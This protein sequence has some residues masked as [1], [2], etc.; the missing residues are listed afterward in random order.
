MAEKESQV[1]RT[2]DYVEVAAAE[3]QARKKTR[4]AKGPSEQRALNDQK[5]GLAQT[6]SIE[7]SQ[8][9]SEIRQMQDA[10]G[11][12]VTAT[13]GQSDGPSEA[14]AMLDAMGGGAPSICSAGDGPSDTRAMDDANGTATSI[15]AHDGD[16]PSNL[17]DMRDAEG[18]PLLRH[19]Q[20]GE[21]PADQ[22]SL[23]DYRA[24]SPDSVETAPRPSTSDDAVSPPSTVQESTEPNLLAV[25][26]ENVAPWA[27]SIHLEERLR[28][29]G[30]MTSKVSAQLEVLEDAVK[31]LGKRIER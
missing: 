13:T 28:N 14:R 30:V 10:D 11:G 9:A 5:G 7:D 18:N 8:G 31:R 19:S 27:L 16:G 22:K 20:D 4:T 29:L 23:Q 1:F 2:D 21:G 12:G 17:R 25:A 6:R 26:E 15:A 3:G 24:Y